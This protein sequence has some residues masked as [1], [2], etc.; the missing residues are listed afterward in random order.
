MS[1]AQPNQ[2]DPSDRDARLEGSEPERPD[3]LMGA[4]EGARRESDA[5]PPD[6][7]TRPRPVGAGPAPPPAAPTHLKL[8]VPPPAAPAEAPAP[9][10]APAPAE[11][12]AAPPA[13]TAPA[14]DAVPGP[15]TGVWKAAASSIP[16]LTEQPV[17]AAPGPSRETSDG[18]TQ[19]E[20]GAKAAAPKP[21][22]T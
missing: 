12:P 8:V 16:R 21:G 5:A 18:F 19:D 14:P 13:G 6:R 9:P 17:A 7:R 22:P 11:A 2:P 20:A 3:W 4:E 15:G 10:E 1:I